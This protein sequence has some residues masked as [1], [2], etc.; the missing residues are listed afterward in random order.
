MPKSLT[1]YVRC[2]DCRHCLYEE[3]LGDYGEVYFEGFSCQSNSE[4]RSIPMSDDLIPDKGVNHPRVCAAFDQRKCDSCGR[5]IRLDPEDGSWKAWTE[6]EHTCEPCLDKFYAGM[7]AYY[8]ERA[9]RDS[10]NKG[11]QIN[12]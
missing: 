2:S 11:G 10:S 5:P 4:E 7:E 8:N 1:L 3:E 12:E 6:L 9:K